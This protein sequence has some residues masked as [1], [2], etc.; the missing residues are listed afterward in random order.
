MATN[1]IRI[2]VLANASQAKRELNSTATT[3]EKISGKFGR[4]R[5]PA[6]AALGGIA[7]G[8][9]KAVDAASDLNEETSKSE[10]IFGKQSGAI[11]SWARNADTA[12]GQSTRQA[13]E[14]AAGFGMIGQKA[15]LSGTETA[16]FAKQFT[17]L[18]SDL[19]SF[20]N[21]SP[22][23]AI[24][25][26]SAAMRGESEPIRKYGVLLDDATLKARAMKMGLIATT[27]EALTPQQKALAAS[28]EILAQTG[29]AQGDFARTSNGAANKSR[30]L[31]AQSE[32]LKAKLG[33]GLLPAYQQVLS[34]ASKFATVMSKHPGLVKAAV[35]VIAGLALA[36]LALGAAQKVATAA[37]IA[38][39]GVMAVTTA[40]SKAATAASLGTRIGLAALA[41]QTAVT[42]A[43]TK[44]A[45][46]AQWALNAAMTANPVGL[47]ILAIVAL[48]AV[49]V[50]AWKKS[51]TFRSIVIGA[52]NAIKSATVAVWGAIKKVISTV[53]SVMKTIIT[54]YIR[55]YV[56]VIK[57]AWNAI[58]AATNAVWNGVKTAVRAAVTVVLTV[59]RSIKSRVIGIFSGAGS[60]LLGAGKKI[61]SGLI[62]G[63]KNMFGAV[64]DTLGNLTSKLTSWKGPPKTDAR[65]LTPAGESIIQGLI[66]GFDKKSPKVKATLKALSKDISTFDASPSGHLRLKASDVYAS[67]QGSTTGSQTITIKLT[68]Q[69][70]SQ[71]QR[72][73]EIALDLDAFEKAGGRRR[74]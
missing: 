51:Q 5:A 7:Y 67:N 56:T 22:E 36:V 32:N 35:V 26:I 12:L 30:I 52:W 65:L 43:V 27:K 63:I 47:V 57:T 28:R 42:S 9:K 59:L 72:G 18:S 34:I 46:A 13:L 44:A 3:A 60:W 49:F 50:I 24:T 70:I 37:Q 64:R 4:M 2:A 11:K 66:D 41:V 45:A 68:A 69:Q 16:K 19:A 55:A 20:N 48:V 71:V 33:Q 39:S 6:I 62:E 14:A 31:A 1:A 8:A 10:V 40:V 58:K 73:R 38:Y 15:G 54:T 29:K 17:G 61:V 21:T 23:E 53:F 25:A 74:S